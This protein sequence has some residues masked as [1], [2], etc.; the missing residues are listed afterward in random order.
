MRRTILAL[1]MA[2]AHLATPASTTLPMKGTIVKPTD[3]N[4]QYIGRICFQNPE[5]PRF[6]FPGT[7]INA[8]FTGTSLKLWAKPKSGYFMAQ[9]DQAAPFK[10]CV[11]G[12]RDSV[13]TIAT[14]LP[15][16]CH[17]V[18]L[19]YVIEGYELK[20]DFRGFVLDKGC[21]LLPPPPCLSAPLSSS[22]TALPAAMVT[23]PS[24]PVILLNMK[25][26]TT[27]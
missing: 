14:A 12:E 21:T 3:K 20:P 24:W 9:I 16:G 2:V 22:A 19:M 11:M 7:Q 10:V 26:R 1:F 23:K 15:Q 17:T 8:C 5:R 27:I 6:T 25:P 13:V 18:R 4:I